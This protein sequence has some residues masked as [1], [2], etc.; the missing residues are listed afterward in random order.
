M[1]NISTIL[2]LMVIF[3]I[4][5]LSVFSQTEGDPDK[6]WSKIVLDPTAP[7]N[8]VPDHKWEPVN[9]ETKYYDFGSGITVEPNFRPNGTTNSTQSE[10]SVDVHPTDNSI[11]FCSANATP[12]PV[13]GIY[14]TGVYW[15]LDGA[16][17]WTA[18]DNPP[19]GSNSGDPVS[20]IGS[21]GY[22]Y[23]NY[24]SN[25]GG[26][27]ISR[28]TDNGATWTSY[29]V[30][31]NPG[32]LADKNHM[33]V[34]K[35]SGSPYENRLYCSWTDFGGVN[36]DDVVLRWSSN[37]GQ[38]WSA[39][40]INLSNSLSPGSHA[41]GTN[42]QTGPNGEVYV[43]YAIYDAWPGGE[44][45]IG[46]SKSTDGGATWTHARIYSAVNFG[47]R[48][49]LSSKSGIRVASFPVMAVDRTSGTYSGNIYICWPQRGV[50]P[51]GTDPDIVLIKS[52]D[53]GSTWSSPV[54][55]ND[56]AM[57]NGKDQY[58]PWCTVD[59][60]TGQLM[61]VF[62][63]SR[64]VS[65]NQAD[66]YMARSLDGGNTFEN[67]K[68]SDAPHT[69]APISGLASG[70][71]GDYIG[72]A[73]HD[74]VAYPYWGENRTGIYQGWMS[75]VTF[76]PPCPVDPPSNP[77]PANGATVVPISLP[78]LTWTNGAGANQVEVW[79]GEAGSMTMVYDGTLIS[80]WSVPGPLEYNTTYNWRIKGKNDTCT[81]SGPVWAFTT[82][83]SPGVLFIEPFTD[84][85]CWTPIGP[86]G[87]T[88]WSSVSSINAGGAAPEL[89]L[90]W[91]PSF[92][93]LSQLLSCVI[94]ANNDRDLKLTFVHFLDNYS[95]TPSPFLGVAVSYDGGTT[96]TSLWEFQP[97]SN[98]GPE[99]K[100]LLFTTPSSGS[101]N[102]Q[103]II[104]CNG[105]SFNID[106][107]YL[108][109]MMLEDLTIPVELS[110]FTAAVNNNN[111]ELKWNT[112]TETNNQG[113]DV[114]R[115]TG[116][117]SFEKIGFVAGFGTTTEP[118]AYS[119]SDVNVN[120]TEY[121]YR[122]KQVDFDGSY[123]Y[124]NEV[125]VVV[126][127]PIEYALEQ[128]YP[129]P[130]NPSTTIKYSI[131]EDGFVKLAVYNMLGE[132]VASLI[133]SN[134]KAGRY[135]ISFNAEN[136]A[137]GVYIYRLESANYTAS[138]KLMLLR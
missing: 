100:E 68:V 40:S 54:R 2:L 103:L 104:Y 115:K 88:N 90:S 20:V 62:Y 43:T 99:P 3:G 17:T 94:P 72:L 89:E 41:Q 52:T 59:Q 33:M 32:S 67:F 16:S 63:D 29:T 120:A 46:F 83:L 57:N 76:G 1:K 35:K 74:D 129:N 77:N 22:F 14:G 53:G 51:A 30:A 10:T 106:Y 6:I 5:A 121:T 28:S 93:G 134:Q 81:V 39:S 60:S 135:E 128:N 50:S 4:S 34:D 108:D 23:E 69:P 133:E 123:E 126:E 118:K 36:S 9:S 58:F 92:N 98:V 18:F 45:A 86:L 87:L 101:E 55:V 7:G 71:A 8:V 26:Q 27:G 79:F 24:I 70:Y 61:L 13:S 64:D 37:F 82:E 56:D 112:A 95:G 97:N 44:D 84:L 85:S 42:V 137:S 31:P 131:P 15:S 109:E 21:N 132:Q 107:W 127:L 73:A 80:S 122:L 49:N 11:I 130:F 25:P 78:Q 110:S 91:T 19:F 47:I 136:L 124:S 113:F 117:G 12:W 48:G 66:V 125:N 111:V 105:N 96:S 116:N 138:K 65:N 119:Y 114:E 75:V 102:L 38:N